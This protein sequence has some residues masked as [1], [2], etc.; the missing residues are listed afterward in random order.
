MSNSEDA[1]LMPEVV[2]M[3]I[4]PTA[5]VGDTLQQERTISP[6]PACLATESASAPPSQLA[7]PLRQHQCPRASLPGRS[8]SISALVPACLATASA[9]A[10]PSQLAW[11]LRQHQRPRASLP[12]HGV[13]IS[14]TVPACL[15]TASASAPPSQLALP[16]RQHQRPRSSLPCHCVSIFAPVPACLAGASVWLLKRRCA[17]HCPWSA[18]PGRR[19][20]IA[21]RKRV[22]GDAVG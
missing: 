12:G 8:V 17:P 21:D 11:Q 14:A 5:L 1:G 19:P 22:N 9:S 16:L 6:E 15:A 18:M 7:W 3:K 2:C 4:E 13:S 20:G 10:P